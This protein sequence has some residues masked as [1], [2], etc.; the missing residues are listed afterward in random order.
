MRGF[1][2]GPYEVVRVLGEGGFARTFEARHR[3]LGTKACLKVS[4]RREY[5]DLLLEEGRLLWDLHHPSLPTLRDVF[6]TAEG[7]A[8]A[9][10][11]VEGTP[12]DRAGRLSPSV[13][14]R[15]LGRLLKA[16]KVLHFRGIVHNDIK[17]ANII[18]EPDRHGVVLVDFGVASLRPTSR[19]EAPGY[20]PIFVAPEVL[21]GR[22][23]TPE[24]DFY[25]LG[26]TLLEC[27]GGDVE[28]RELPRDV[29][30]ELLRLL[31]A[32]SRPEPERRPHDP[33]AT[34]P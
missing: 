14:T 32:M 9:M 4:R 6:A 7:V 13:A 26:L 34:L 1:A 18:L 21:G 19:S 20:T 5:D 28:R 25:S 16:L 33:L 15:V 2:V 8:L 22:P 17:P 30:E 11:F 29:P 24:S 23:P 27:L 12:L 31:V 10:R 3:L